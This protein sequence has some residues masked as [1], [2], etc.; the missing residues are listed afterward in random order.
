MCS[1]EQV[2][3]TSEASRRR[4][5][6]STRRRTC[7]TRC[8]RD[9]TPSRGAGRWPCNR[10]T[11]LPESR[12]PLLLAAIA[13]YTILTPTLVMRRHAACTA[14]V[15]A[16]FAGLGFYDGSSVRRR[17]L[18]GGVRVARHEFHPCDGV[19]E[20]MNSRAISCPRRVPHRRQRDVRAGLCMAA[21]R[22]SGRASAPSCRAARRGVHPPCFVTMAL[23][24]AAKTH[25]HRWF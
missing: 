6:T 12:H 11:R 1:D 9:A 24:L 25:L 17:I 18:L 15:Y 10:S 19:H 3:I 8:P 7:A 23:G 21:A 22:S 16:V 2:S 5:T 4:V 20:V 14:G 13:I